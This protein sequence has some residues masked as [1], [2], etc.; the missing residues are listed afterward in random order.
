MN[1][2]T[3]SIVHYGKS[4]NTSRLVGRL[5][6]EVDLPQRTEIIVVKNSPL[7]IPRRKNLLFLQ[8][9]ENL[10]FGKGHNEAFK[11]SRC[12]YFLVLNPDI[13]PERMSIK[14]L[15]DFMEN[16]KDAGIAGPMLVLPD[17]QRQYSARKFYGYFEALFSRAPV[18][19]PFSRNFYARH[20]MKDIDLK[21][22]SEVDWVAGASL[23]ARTL[24]VKKRGFVFD[25]RY[26]LYFEDVDLCLYCKK[27]GKKVFYVPKSVMTHAHARESGKV[28]SRAGIH[29]ASS[30]IKF[31]FK[32]WG[33]PKNA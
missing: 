29:H 25:P 20:L 10:G 14:T 19:E 32:H 33:F 1:L 23:I 24:L 4:K 30:T 8:P 11:I 27:N 17:G 26:F 3:I 2:L 31:L 28:L 7:E 15:V 9:H 22:P 12:K 5:L 18:K 13:S 21:N 6:E 16:N